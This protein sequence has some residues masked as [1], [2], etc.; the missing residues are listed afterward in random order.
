MT[1]KLISKNCQLSESKEASSN[2]RASFAHPFW[3]YVRIRLCYCVLSDATWVLEAKWVCV[4]ACECSFVCHLLTRTNAKCDG[5]WEQQADGNADESN[6]LCV[7]NYFQK[8][9]SLSTSKNDFLH[10][11]PFSSIL[12]VAYWTWDRKIPHAGN[13]D[14]TWVHISVAK[15]PLLGHPFLTVGILIT[16]CMI[17]FGWHP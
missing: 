12:S 5:Q 6:D 8:E 16:L 9:H 15:Q 4:R 13:W 14:R 7:S 10:F 11:H 3:L 17:A 1:V 2:K